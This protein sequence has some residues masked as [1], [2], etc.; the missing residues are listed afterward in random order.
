MAAQ[1][2]TQLKAVLL[3]LVWS[4]GVSAA[5]FLALK[6]T[7]GLRPTAEVEQEGLDLAEHGERAYNY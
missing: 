6:Y 5:L 4:G 3:T 1:F 2:I 7:I